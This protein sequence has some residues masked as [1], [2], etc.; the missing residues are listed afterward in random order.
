MIHPVTVNQ[1][2][3]NGE[4]LVDKNEELE[5]SD[6]N[7]AI[8]K[9]LIETMFSQ[10]EK[11]DKSLLNNKEEKKSDT[12]TISVSALELYER[13]YGHI[14]Y[15]NDFER[16][17]IEFEQV[18]FLRVEESQTQV[19]EAE[20]LI[21]DLNGNGIELTDVRRG[22]GVFFD[23]TGDGKPEQ[24]SWVSANDGMLVYDRNGNGKIDSGKELFGDQHG[25]KDGFE[26]L[27]K[28]DTDKNN[29]INKKDPIYQKL[30]IWQDLN[31]NG[32][33][34]VVELKSIARYGIDSID[35]QKDNTRS[36]IAGNRVE[37][38]ASYH[39]GTDSGKVGE[40]FF[41]YLV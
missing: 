12:I 32:F 3:I 21:L 23:I 30:K 2:D 10:D 27:S 14:V 37:G 25:A 36:T 8:Q 15:E 38:Y 28:F 26:E 33:S 31:Q 6:P 24:V 29:A 11:D 18:K 19:Q 7:L 41:N 22:D 20:P 13:K 39:Y 34:E 5:I 9:R 40:V 16:L 17:E 4:L 1:Y 35:L